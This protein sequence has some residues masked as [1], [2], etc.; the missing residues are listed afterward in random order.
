MLPGGGGGLK[1]L[2]VM[3]KSAENCKELGIGKLLQ[4]FCG[5][6]KAIW[7]ASS[8]LKPGAADRLRAFRPASLTLQHCNTVFLFVCLL[9]L[10]TCVS[11]A[12][13]TSDMSDK[14]DKLD[15]SDT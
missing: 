13:A 15:K 5:M 4:E 12:A 10:V 6:V 8:W 7:H 3:Q 1:T 2:R 14:T 11:L 9:S